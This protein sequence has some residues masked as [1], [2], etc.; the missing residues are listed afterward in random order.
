MRDTEQ[1][2][3]LEEGG[4]EA[5]IRREVLPYTPDAWIDE[6]DEDRL[7]RLASPAT[8]T[9]RSRCARLTKSG[10]T[11]W[12]LK[13]RPKVCSRRSS[14]GMRHERAKQPAESIAKTINDY[15]A[16]EMAEPTPEHVDRWVKQFRKDV[17]VPV[18]RE[19]DHVL[20]TTYLTKGWVSGFLSK[21]VTNEKLAGANPCTFW[22]KAHFLQIQKNGHSQQEMLELFDQSLSHQCGI[23]IDDCGKAG[24]DYIYMDDVMFSGSRV[25]DDL[26]SWIE[27]DAPSK[28]T[29]HVVLAAIHKLGHFLTKNRLEK[30]ISTVGKTIE[31]KYWCAKTIENRKRY[32]NDSE[33]LWPVEIPD[34][35]DVQEYVEQP[36]KFPFEPR[37]AGGSLGPFSS[38]EGRQL[39]ERELLIAGVS[40]RGLSQNPKDILRPLGFS[41]F[42]LGFGSMIVTFRNCPNNCPLA[43]WWGDPAATSGPFHWYPLFASEDLCLVMRIPNHRPLT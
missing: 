28:A 20:K 16:G 21:L 18:L 23:N 32:R 15:C 1:V 9:S 26:A 12:P 40:I 27:N 22:S 30:F 41:P 39:L 19:L 34:D 24:G 11:S 13:R 10:P 43:L 8:S 31:I 17:Q 6:A 4:I 37:T 14:G 25:G 2:P 38:E 42:G 36:H 29:V 7:T 33:V 35:P 5:F 3:L